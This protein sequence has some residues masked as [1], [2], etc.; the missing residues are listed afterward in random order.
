VVV[1]TLATLAERI[2]ADELPAPAT[3]IVGEVARRALEEQDLNRAASERG[4]RANA[5]AV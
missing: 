3:L 2:R 1:G 5:A 4:P